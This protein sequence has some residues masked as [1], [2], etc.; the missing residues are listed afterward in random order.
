MKLLIVES[1]RT[2]RELLAERCQLTF[3]SVLVADTVQ[4]GLSICRADAVDVLLLDLHQAAR[5]L[6]KVSR[7]FLAIRPGLRIVGIAP[8]TSHYVIYRV[9][10]SPLH[11]YLCK[12][13]DGLLT[14]MQA[15][16]TVGEGRTFF[17]EAAQIL[18]SEMQGD[19]AA[20]YKILSNRELELLHEFCAGR[21]NESIAEQIGLRPST[22]LWHRRNIMK[23]LNIHASIDLMRFGLRYGF[24]HRDGLFDKAENGA[25]EL[26]SPG[27]D[28]MLKESQAPFGQ[29]KEAAPELA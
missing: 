29:V 12:Q 10:N 18:R 7:E 5:Q 11:G 20:F 13:K 22:V 15:L 28:A 24:V 3:S 2:Y 6:L 25:G 19:P 26:P 17:S 1:W 8:E 27:A 23:K 21:T 16:T 14:I 9:Y 4:V